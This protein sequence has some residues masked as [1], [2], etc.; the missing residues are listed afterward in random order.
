MKLGGKP[1]T[2]VKLNA[3]GLVFEGIIDHQTIPDLIVNLPQ[4][5]DAD[6][7]TG[8][9]KVP[10]LDISAVTRIDSA[11]LAFLIDWGKQHLAHGQKIT[12]RG[13]RGQARQLIETMKLNALF[14][15]QAL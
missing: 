14:E 3:T 2:R 1:L 9:D 12:L 6:I 7:D 10:V 15:Q 4:I 11:G 8:K 13:A 5:K